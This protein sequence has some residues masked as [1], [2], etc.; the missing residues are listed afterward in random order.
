MAET[1]DSDGISTKQHEI[2]AL[3][4]RMPKRVLNTLAHRMDFA[5]MREAYRR[6]RKDGALGVDGVSAREFEA[7]LEENLKGLLER[8]KSGSYRAPAV[9]RIN[10]PKGDGRGTRPIGIPTLED[11]VLQRAVLM[12]LEPVYEQD[13]LDCSYGFRAGRS[14][15]QALQALWAGLMNIEGGWVIDLDIRAYFDSVQRQHLGQ[16]LDQRVRD[17]VIR[18]AIGKWL[19][20]GVM[21][22]GV[23]SYPKQ[24][25]PQGGVISPLLSNIYLHEVLDT[26][27]EDEVKPRLVGRA[28]MVRYADDAVLCFEHETDARRVLAVLPKRLAR[29]GLELNEDKTQLVDF[30]RPGKRDEEHN[31]AG[32][33]PHGFD[34]LGFTHYWGRSRKGRWL[35]KRKTAKSRFSRALVRV[36]KWCR[37]N[38]HLPVREQCKALRRRLMGHDAYFG[39]TGNGPALSRFHLEVER[40]WRKWLDRR[41]HHARMNWERFRRLLAN[42]PLPPPRVVHSVYRS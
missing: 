31:G 9:R 10:I 18:R 20:A 33:G 28:F 6:V 29:F 39:I 16:M 22:D 17:G 40:V 1:W 11:K 24:G 23:V 13:F 5:W 41:S 32:R 15:H 38:R 3:A 36:A 7:N 34:V 37:Y 30:R 19:N 27:F 35:V 4:K 8:F 21:E 42:Y 12:V 14:A 25:T 26:W 2:A